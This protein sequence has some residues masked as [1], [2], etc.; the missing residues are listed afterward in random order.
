MTFPPALIH[1]GQQS[2]GAA[3]QTGCQISGAARDATIICRRDSYEA[4]P[5]VR[6]LRQLPCEATYLS[7]AGIG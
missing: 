6:W 7:Q 5:F 2:V 1:A 4:R 3:N